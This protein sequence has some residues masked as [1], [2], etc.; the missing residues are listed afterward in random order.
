MPHFVNENGLWAADA[1]CDGRSPPMTQRQ[2]MGFATLFH[3]L[4]LL[5]AEA[6]RSGFG[7]NMHRG[8]P[9]RAE[10]Q[11]FQ[12]SFNPSL[13]APKASSSR[14]WERPESAIEA[15]SHCQPQPEGDV[16]HQES[17]G[18]SDRQSQARADDD[19]F[20]WVDLADVMTVLCRITDEPHG[21]VTD[22][23]KCVLGGAKMILKQ[24]IN[25]DSMQSDDARRALRALNLIDARGQAAPTD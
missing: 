6:E 17:S 15:R 2:Y 22:G 10:L 7:P 13:A 16:H 4:A 12:A 5:A 9:S 25:D 1:D 14:E 3:F 20:Q 21:E 24:C 18:S 8:W 19:D 23:W 11:S